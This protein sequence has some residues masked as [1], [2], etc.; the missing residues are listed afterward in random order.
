MS[1]SDARSS[2]LFVL[3]LE[4]ALMPGASRGGVC[5][6]MRGACFYN[7]KA[8][9]ARLSLFRLPL[10][11]CSL[12]SVKCPLQLLIIFCLV[13]A[14]RCF[15]LSTLCSLMYDHCSLLSS[16]LSPVMYSNPCALVPSTPSSLP[17][18]PRTNKTLPV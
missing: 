10:H 13:R 4:L 9:F 7:C 16:A 18:A 17:I 11:F 1:P 5:K 12:Y 6:R 3:S 8:F 15:L 14:P 2:P